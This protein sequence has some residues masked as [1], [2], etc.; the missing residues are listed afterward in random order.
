VWTYDWG[1]V[2]REDKRLKLKILYAIAIAFM[3]I[4]VALIGLSCWQYHKILQLQEDYTNYQIST[5]YLRIREGVTS[6]DQFPVV[7]AGWYKCNQVITE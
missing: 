2:G 1:R 5:D 4:F 7:K 6:G 3:A